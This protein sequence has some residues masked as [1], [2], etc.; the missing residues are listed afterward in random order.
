[1]EQRDPAGLVHRAITELGADVL[2]CGVDATSCA[3]LYGKY[4]TGEGG[5]R[6]YSA[7]TLL[8]E[9]VISTKVPASRALLIENA[10][11]FASAKAFVSGKP[12]PVPPEP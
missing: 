6:S 10:A 9:N 12:S 2:V 1:M 3:P 4:R 5:M 8:P 11:R 7:S